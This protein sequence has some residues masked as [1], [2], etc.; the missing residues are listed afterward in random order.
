LPGLGRPR[1]TRRSPVSSSTWRRR[2][3]RRIFDAQVRREWGRYVGEPAA[4]LC[5]E[6]I[7][8]FLQREL[9]G[10]RGPVLELGPG[11][12]RFTPIILRSSRGP[13]HL[14]DLSRPMI[15][16][17]HR[18]ALKVS[19]RKYRG[20]VQAAGEHLPFRD[21]T[22]GAVV[23]VGN[24]VGFTGKH[25]EQLLGE[26]SRVMRPGG[27][28]IVDFASPAGAL[29]EFTVRGSQRGILREILRRPGHY[30]VW[31]IL[32]TGRQPYAPDRMARMEF[33][34]FTPLEAEKALSGARFDLLERQAVA[35]VSLWRADV[36]AKARR[37]AR[38]WRNL[39][40]IEEVVG[41]RGGALEMGSG[42]LVSARR[43][44]RGRAPR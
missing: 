22:F 26:L 11:P 20:S 13:V 37:D 12:G 4:H 14:A 44:G 25:A 18:R 24:L 41:R 35:P 34:F 23:C 1:R 33:Q 28:L 42:L 31:T 17:A 16:S 6:L 21:H 30:L 29:V 39:I 19:P 8:R 2:H 5:R 7:E 15:R 32:A 27:R 10:V 3:L 36:A 43:R 40:E 9:R 38:S